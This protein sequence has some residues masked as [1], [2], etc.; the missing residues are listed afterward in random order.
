VWTWKIIA[1]VPF[2][3]YVSCKNLEGEVGRPVIDQE[4]GR[5]GQ[6]LETPNIKFIVASRFNEQGKKASTVDGFIP[7]EIGFKVDETNVAEAYRRVH[8]AVSEVLT[9]IASRRLQQLAEAAAKISEQLR[10]VYEEF[11]RLSS[12]YFT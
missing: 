5:V 8:R 9:A 12:S 7:I 2:R 10:N 11:S 3:V 6:L 4:V 1:G